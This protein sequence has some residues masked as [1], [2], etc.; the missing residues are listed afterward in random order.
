MSETLTDYYAEVMREVFN[1]GLSLDE[2]VVLT[3]ILDAYRLHFSE[4]CVSKFG[5]PEQTADQTPADWTLSEAIEIVAQLT[6]E[7]DVKPGDS[8]EWGSLCNTRFLVIHD[9]PQYHMLTESLIDR[10]LTHKC[11][12]RVELSPKR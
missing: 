5:S 3:N 2:A 11:V 8:E 12:D 10:L 9:Q 1:G 4:E 6:I 7:A